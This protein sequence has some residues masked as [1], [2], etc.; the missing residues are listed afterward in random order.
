MP[1]EMLKYGYCMERVHALN[2]IYGVSEVVAG[3]STTYNGY[4]VGEVHK[5]SCGFAD[6]EIEL[7]YDQDYPASPYYI[8]NKES[9]LEKPINSIR[10]YITTNLRPSP[11]IERKFYAGSVTT[12]KAITDIFLNNLEE[13]KA[14]YEKDCNEKDMKAKASR[15]EM[16]LKLK[17]EFEPDEK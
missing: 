1:K 10:Y 8:R 4:I 5:V 2:K 9:D 13:L 12:L 7:E 15:H 11:R 6:V 16:Y 17:A 3:S 14:A